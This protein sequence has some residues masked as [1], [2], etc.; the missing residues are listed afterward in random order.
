MPVLDD[1]GK[2]LDDSW[3]FYVRLF[4]HFYEGGLKKMGFDSLAS[5]SNSVNKTRFNGKKQHCH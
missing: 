1:I 4:Q 5:Q 2:N 3:D